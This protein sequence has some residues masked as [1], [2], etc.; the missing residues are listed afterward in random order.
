MAAILFLSLKAS[1]RLN[2]ARIRGRS[3]RAARTSRYPSQ[4]SLR[5]VRK[6]DLS[7]QGIAF[8]IEPKLGDRTLL[9][10]S[11]GIG[12]GYDVMDRVRYRWDINNPALHLSISPKFFYNRE[13]RVRKSKLSHL[14][15]GNYVGVRVKYI[16]R[17]VGAEASVYDTFLMNLH[18]GLQ[19]AIAARWSFGAHIGAGYAV[20]V[21]DLSNPYDSFY[22]SFDAKFS[23]V[24]SSPKR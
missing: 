17:G 7:G 4:A 13:Q 16:T 19:R 22:P 6:I 24:L 2:H 14:N 18:W 10:L 5:G 20:D 1:Y 3:E 9:D 15:S 12:G 8:S 23:Y 11:L 21:T